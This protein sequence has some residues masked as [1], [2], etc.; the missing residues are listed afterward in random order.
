MGQALSIRS[1]V[2]IAL[3][4]M[5]ASAQ[6]ASQAPTSS[7]DTAV[8]PWGSLSE[9][10]RL[11]DTTSAGGIRFPSILRDASVMGEVRLA[12]LIDASGRPESGMRSNRIWN[13][14]TPG[15]GCHWLARLRNSTYVG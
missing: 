10:P 11:L 4:S 8:V 5:S 2:A 6:V 1:G 14:L 15:S 3:V 13:L 7:S 12:M 9:R